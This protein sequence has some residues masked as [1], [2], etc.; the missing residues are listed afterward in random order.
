MGRAS[1]A[2]KAKQAARAK[3][4]RLSALTVDEAKLLTEVPDEYTYAIYQ[5]DGS[6]VQL[7]GKEPKQKLADGRLYIKCSGMALVPLQEYNALINITQKA[8]AKQLELVKQ[9][10]KMREDVRKQNT[11]VAPTA[12]ETAEVD[13]SKR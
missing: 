13:G 12:A 3:A 7:T 6:Y 1:K 4:S 5:L 11:I 2:K 9:L 10:R 8:N